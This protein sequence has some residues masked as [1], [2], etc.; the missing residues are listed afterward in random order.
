MEINK[1]YCMD[2]I[3]GLE[4]LEEGSI[5]LVLT[6]PP[7]K[8]SYEGIG[9]NRGSK[10][11]KYHYSNDVGEPLYV[12]EDVA[13]IL[14]KKLKNDGVFL[15]NLGFNKDSGALRP[16]QIVD[17]FR[18]FGWFCPDIII[19]HKQNPIP[20]TAYQLTNAYEFLFVLTK[21]PT[22]KLSIKKREYIHN[23]IKTP[24]ESGKTDHNAAFHIDM[25]KFCISHFSKEGN[26]VLDMFMGSGTTAVACKQL[27]R[28]F[29]GFENNPEY[30]KIANN[31]LDN[32]NK[33]L[34][35][36]E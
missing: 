19:W 10:T 30:C 14:F 18:T 12:I 1:I 28:R 31:R 8:N 21:I 7:Y 33:E 27:G 4:Q 22:Y 5:D 26:L 29:I 16:F 25:A 36:I 6:S 20:N 13:S 17:R 11:K 23:V 24:V 2:C 3:E 9:I 32:L 35:K 15:L 34:E